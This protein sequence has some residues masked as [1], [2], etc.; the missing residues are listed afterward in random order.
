MQAWFKFQI[1]LIDFRAKYRNFDHF[2]YLQ[3]FDSVCLVKH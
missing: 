3:H 2:K 1:I